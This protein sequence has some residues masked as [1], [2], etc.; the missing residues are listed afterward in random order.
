M[1]TPK[2]HIKLNTQRQ[3]EG[4][5]TFRYANRFPGITDDDDIPVPK[6]HTQMA[7]QFRSSLTRFESNRIFRSEKRNL[8]LQILRHIDYIR[9]QF[10]SQFDTT[11][12]FSEYYQSFGIEAVSFSK[13]GTEGLFAI[14]DE[15][16][17]R[18]FLQNIENFTRNVLDKREDVGFDG[19]IKYI[20]DFELLTSLSILKVNDSID[21]ITFRLADFPLTPEVFT[22]IWPTLASYLRDNNLPYI[23]NPDSHSLEVTGVIQDQLVEIVDNF[24]IVLSVVSNLATVIG[25][26]G[27]STAKRS[28]GFTIE[29][30]GVDTPIIGIIDTGISNRTPLVD[31]LINDDSYN[32]TTT[33]A[34]ID[35]ANHGTGVAALAALG[36]R[37]YS[38]NYRGNF[39]AD[40]R[41]LSIKIMDA[42]RGNLLH[43]DVLRVLRRVKLNYPEI[44]IFVLTT[45]SVM[46][47]SDD[48]DFSLYAAELDKFSHENDCLLFICTTNNNAACDDNLSYNVGYF[49]REVSNLSSPAECMN[50]VTVGAASDNITGN[51][52]SAISTGKEYP[53]LY[54][55]KHH[56][57]IRKF[58]PTNK[59]NKHY[60]KPDIIESGGDYEASEYF[61]AQGDQASL[62]I[63]SADP[64]ESFFNQ[65]GTSYSAPLAANLAARIQ[66]LYPGLKAQ[67][68][69]ALIINGANKSFIVF[70]DA[71]KNLLPR[72][73]GN[74]IILPDKSLFSNDNSITFILEEEIEPGNMQLYPI[75][76]PAYLYDGTI[77]KKT[78]ILKITATLS[79]SFLPYITNQLSYCPIHISF[80]IFRNVTDQSIMTQYPKSILRNAWTQDAFH[81]A[82]PLP[83]SNSQK[84]T[85]IVGKKELIQ[86]NGIFKIAVNCRLHPQIL[87]GQET[88]YKI[89]HKFSLVIRIE[90]NQTEANATGNLY[91]EM[92]AI[93]NIENI[94]L[95]DI[96]LE[97][98]V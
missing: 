15:Q 87:S 45:G 59:N 21:T 65:I 81:K 72:V 80:S 48:E 71:Y 46:N 35:N 86:E 55:R 52:T 30:S 69:K 9:I 61:I 82:K 58:Y 60:F 84:I 32:L 56:T 54:T 12:Y 13:F 24:D 41:L 11:K 8:S 77:S 98:T 66:G 75:H 40:A 94:A 43:S 89:P 67:T 64:S 27:V 5:F 6:D 2:P 19:R 96:E 26:S 17:F 51:S 79:F 16:R 39:N 33:S 49:N 68:I 18:L 57:N 93:N 74:G 20:K 85:F 95:A 1:A 63:L 28:Y 37:P 34:F 14:I 23:F 88:K 62:E 92:I 91:N 31:I 3:T 42:G 97:G 90:E 47:K 36:K 29:Q 70:P 73:A 53:A 7:R 10:Q 50:N 44:R 38:V 25:P 76:M 4:K 83:Y 22:Q 78:G